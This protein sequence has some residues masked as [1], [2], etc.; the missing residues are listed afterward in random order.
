LI[1]QDLANSAVEVSAIVRALGGRQPS[2]IL[3]IGAGYGRTAFALMHLFPKATYTVVD[4]DPALATSRWYLSKLFGHDRLR[5]LKPR[6][7][8]GVEDGTVDLSLWISSLQEM[9]QEQVAAYFA[10]MD[11][12]SAS[13]IVYLKQWFRW[14]NPIDGI[15]LSSNDYP[16]PTDWRLIFRERAP[17]QTHFWQ[18]AWRVEPGA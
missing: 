16:I 12:V 14:R 10:F 5:F 2:A 15:E 4:I 3:E 11:R 7:V 18:A 9:T 8:A 1:S 13:G 17:V 6:E